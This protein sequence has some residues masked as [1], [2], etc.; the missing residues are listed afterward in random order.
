M[1]G[2][3]TVQSSTSRVRVPVNRWQLYGT[4]KRWGLFL[5]EHAGLPQIPL[6]G[7]M[8]FPYGGT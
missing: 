1:E 8:T 2:S 7:E 4:A 6:F 3:Y 5:K